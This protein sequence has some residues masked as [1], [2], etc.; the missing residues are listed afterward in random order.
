[1]RCS[2]ATEVSDPFPAAPWTTEDREKLM[3]KRM[4]VVGLAALMLASCRNDASPTTIPG[5]GTLYTFIGDTPP[6]SDLLSMRLAVTGLA[7]RQRDTTNKVTAF[8]STVHVD[9]ASLRDFST[10]LNLASVPAAAYDEVTV[11]LSG[12]QIVLYDPTQSPPV[13]VVAAVMSTARAVIPLGHALTVVKGKVTALRLDFDLLRSIQ[14]DVN[15]QVSNKLIPVMSASP[16]AVSEGEDPGEFDDL[17]GFVSAVSP[18]RVGETFT[19][20]LTM[21]LLAGTGPAITVNFTDSTE[22]F[23]VSALNQLETG[24]VVEVDAVMDENGNLVAK[25]VEAEDRADLENNKSAFLGCV[26]SVTRDANGNVAQFSFYVREEEPGVSANVPLDSVVVVNVP[27]TTGFQY[28]SRSANFAALPFDATAV[29]RGQ[30]LIVHGEYTKMSNAPTII[31]AN[32]VVLKLQ[33]MQGNFSSLV[34]VESDDRTGAF[35]FSPA[36]TLLQDAPIMVFTNHETVFVNVAGLA[37][38]TPDSILLVKGLPFYQKQ[39]GT[40]NG[41]AVPAGTL[42]ITARQVHKFQ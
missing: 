9:F 4:L 2:G 21:R 35:C 29:A 28:S 18:Y 33:T 10:V 37:E 12:P 1:V 30:E 15:G 17:V 19:G 16:I 20:A 25:T 41:V 38:L 34:Q 24:R 27:S 13:K 3:R 8:S 7:L 36:A 26:V 6:V 40:I 5:S 23:G 22:L 42:V 14:V 31:D 39:A 32:T 11:S